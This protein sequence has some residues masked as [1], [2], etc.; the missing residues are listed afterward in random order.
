MLFRSVSQSRYSDK[1]T[2]MPLPLHTQRMFDL[3]E[4]VVEN[5]I[6]IK[7]DGEPF[8]IKTMKDALIA[9][10]YVNFNNLF[11]LRNGRQQF[12]M[13]HFANTRK[14]FGTD[15]NF[16][17]DKSCTEMFSLKKYD[18]PYMKMQQ[19]IKAMQI[20]QRENKPAK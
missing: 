8:A 3:L 6:V 10:G 11:N 19:A 20:H 14:V 1:I 18:T 15:C 2:T 13:E 16:F 17:F 7:K 5:E 9:I 4:Y 12:Q